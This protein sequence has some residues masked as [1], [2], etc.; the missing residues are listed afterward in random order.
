MIRKSTQKRKTKETDISI[1]LEI[2]NSENSK[3]STPVPFFT[4]M[5]ELFSRHGNFYLNCDIKGDTEVDL[6][7]TVEDTGI[8]LGKA[9]KEALGDKKGI[10]RYGFMLLP[11]DE[12]LVRVALDLSGRPYFKYDIGDIKGKIGNFDLEYCSHFFRSFTYEL[13]LNLHIE[14]LYG[15]DK[16]HIVEAIFKA[17]SRSL[18]EA[19]EIIGNDIPSTKGIL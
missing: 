17:V 15:D 9:F 4:H 6:H 2:G 14:L 7:H 19:V 10:R 13:Q 5:L 18:A 12:S 3:I 16:H 8:V 1:S 11:M